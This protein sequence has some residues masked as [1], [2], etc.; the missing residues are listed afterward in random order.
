[1]Y[2]IWSN[3]KA[4]SYTNKIFKVHFGDELSFISDDW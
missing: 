1:M 3:K 2:Y 4:Y